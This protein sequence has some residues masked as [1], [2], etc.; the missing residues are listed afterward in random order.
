M[1]GFSLSEEGGVSPTAK[2]DAPPIHEN[3]N[4]VIISKVNRSVKNSGRNSI[5]F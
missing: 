2:T 5:L 4:Y 1:S 3:L